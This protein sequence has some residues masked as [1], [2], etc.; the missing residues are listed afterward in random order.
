MAAN[1]SRRLSLIIIVFI[2]RFGVPE[3]VFNLPSY[4]RMLSWARSNRAFYF[5]A[6]C[7][8]SSLSLSRF[9]FPAVA[10]SL[11]LFFFSNV[12]PFS[13]RICR[14]GKYLFCPTMRQ[15]VFDYFAIE[16]HAP[17]RVASLRYFAPA[18]KIAVPHRT[19]ESF[20]LKYVCFSSSIA[21]Y[22]GISFERSAGDRLI[23]FARI[24][25]GFDLLEK[26]INL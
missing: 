18:R 12:R 10:V 6:P 21:N 11:V 1:S 22:K 26:K 20:S 9:L 16:S 7:S 17:H 14:T 8:F 23:L 3:R 24:F 25:F 5:R 4:A 15:A 19:H 13:E 2:A